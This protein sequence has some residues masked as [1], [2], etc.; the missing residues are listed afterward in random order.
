[1]KRLL[2]FILIWSLLVITG[3]IV[4]A[5]SQTRRYKS[6]SGHNADTTAASAGALNRST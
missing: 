1:M 5:N 3:T 6:E 4:S 2:A